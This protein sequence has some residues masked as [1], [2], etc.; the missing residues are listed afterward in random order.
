MDTANALLIAPTWIA[1]V[2]PTNG[3]LT[4]HAI[5]IRGSTIEALAPI[6]QA[7][8]ANPGI[9]ELPLPGHLVTPGLINLHTHAAMSLLRGLGDDLPLARWL[10][11]KIW[12]AEAR[13]ASEIG[14]AHV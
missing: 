3:V 9:A 11:E 7:R 10:E 13:L 5:V 1:P 6:D 12:P 14:R 2:A 8:R 4:D